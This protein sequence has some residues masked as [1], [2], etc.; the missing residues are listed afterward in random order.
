MTRTML[1]SK[2]HRATVTDADLEYVGSCT[3]DADL[4]HAA[5]ILPYEQIAI[6]NVTN[7]ERFET[8]ALEGRSGSGEICI[9]GAAAHKAS[10][11]DVVIIA[12]YVAMDGA[13]AVGHRPRVILVGERN[14]IWQ[15]D[16]HEVPGTKVAVPP[17]A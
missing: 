7:G 17:A 8:Y 4:L 16:D 9:N 6:W 5:D 2:I 11:G 14:T 15:I 12:S 1:K 13:E 3:I 10:P